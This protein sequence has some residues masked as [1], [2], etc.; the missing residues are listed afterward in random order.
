VVHFVTQLAK[1]SKEELA[2]TDQPRIFSLQ[3]LVEVAD[4]NMNRMR[5]VWSR[6]WKELSRH[7]VEVAGHQNTRV[8]TFALDS[9]R[10]LTMKFLE[11]DELAG[12][13]FQAEFLKPFEVIM[14][15]SPPVSRDVKDY[16]IHIISYMANASFKHIRSGWKTVFHICA[17]TTSEFGA[18]EDT[19]QKA[20]EV[21]EK[22][23]GETDYHL[24]VENFTDG[25]RTLLAFGQC[26]VSLSMSLQA[27]AQLL[28]AAVYLADPKT[29]DPPPPPT[30]S[31]TQ[32]VGVQAAPATPAEGGSHPAAHWFPILRG[33]SM[34]ISDPRREVRAQA[35]GGVF[36]ILR[37]HGRQVFDEDTWRMIFNG[38]IKPLFDD[39]HHQLLPDQKDGAGEVPAQSGRLEGNA[40][41]VTMGPPTCLA[42]L[43]HLVRLFDAHVDALAFLLDDVL[44]LIQNCIQHEFEAVARIGVEGFKQLLLLTGKKLKPESWQKVTRSILSLFKDSMPTKL[45]HVDLKGASQLPFS[46]DEVVIQCVVQLLLIDMLQDA[47]AQHYENIPA[48]GIMTLLDALKQSF[49]FAQEFNRQIELRQALKRLGFM[50]EMKQLPGL[51]KQE[52]ESL[53]CS[54]KLLFQVQADPKMQET[55]FAVQAVERLLNL[56]SSVLQNYVSKEKL[57]QERAESAPPPDMSAESLRD[58]EAATVEVEREVM[59]LVPIISEVVVK[60]LKDLPKVQFEKHVHELF[61]LFCELTIVNSREVRVMVREVLLERITPLLGSS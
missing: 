1:V 25:V 18:S 34:M 55:D 56:C 9:L 30:S 52:R 50:R 22:V 28:K 11:K 8:S 48:Q 46:K 60:G 47:A 3:K 19:V 20:F 12:Y 23:T 58:R 38:V 45:M 39:I 42:A 24:F 31:L 21:V 4:Y 49:E 54:L 57:L 27:I 2:L 5:V 7:F 43:T 33:L 36:D 17:S 32:G 44:R 51:L 15:Q 26:K 41:A 59:G 61:P 35:L 29:P 10:Q 53:S 6:L 13:S 37:D 40:T 16:I 14:V